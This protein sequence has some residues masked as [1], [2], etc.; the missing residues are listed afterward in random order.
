MNKRVLQF[1]LVILDWHDH[2]K[3]HSSQSRSWWPSFYCELLLNNNNDKKKKCLADNQ[4]ELECG[5]QL[6]N[7]IMKQV[8]EEFYFKQL[9]RLKLDTG[10]SKEDPAKTSPLFIDRLTQNHYG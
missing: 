8:F 5:N 3:L 10:A 2:Q 7:Y 6:C 1:A 4:P 9:F